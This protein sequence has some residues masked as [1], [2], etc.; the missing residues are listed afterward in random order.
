MELTLMILWSLVPAAMVVLGGLLTLRFFP[1]TGKT[2]YF[3]LYL[4]AAAVMLLYAV[5]ITRY[6]PPAIQAEWNFDAHFLFVPVLTGVMALLLH[7]L[8]GL[9]E[10]PEQLQIPAALLGL[11]AFPALLIQSF[12]ALLYLILGVSIV[13]LIWKLMKSAPLYLTA[14]SAGFLACYLLGASSVFAPLMSV[15]LTGVPISVLLYITPA[16]LVTLAAA[17]I[18]TGLHLPPPEKA[19]QT[20]S[21][22]IPGRYPTLLQI[23]FGLVL[24]AFPV[25]VIS[26]Y[27][28]GGSQVALA[29]VWG[30]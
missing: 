10:L 24:L 18:Y 17:H 1:D 4:A 16:I 22:C 19:S 21:G 12:E 20:G 15:P 14:A 7:N 2:P 5:G 26:L 9:A 30:A 23:G 25:Y 11:S 29:G 8:S 6:F 3:S 28:V 27:S 13:S